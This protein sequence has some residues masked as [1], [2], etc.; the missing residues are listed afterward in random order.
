M[1]YMDYKDSGWKNI[2]MIVSK[3]ECSQL[4]GRK[5]DIP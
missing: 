3:E 2:Y 1:D 4:V 5:S